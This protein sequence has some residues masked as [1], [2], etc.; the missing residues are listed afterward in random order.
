MAHP[1]IRQE[2]Y[3][4]DHHGIPTF[5]VLSALRGA[6][7]WKG[8]DARILTSVRR[9]RSLPSGS[10]YL[11]GTC[12]A[13]TAAGAAVSAALGLDIKDTRRDTALRAV[14]LCLDRLSKTGGVRCCKEAVYASI[15]SALEVLQTC[16]PGCSALSS[17][18]TLCTFHTVLP[19][20]KGPRCPYHPDH[21]S[22]RLA[23]PVIRTKPEPVIRARLLMD[24][25]MEPAPHFS[26]EEAVLRGVDEGSSPPTLRI[27][28][29]RSSVWIG[30]YQ[31]PEEDVN[32]PRARELGIPILRRHNPGGAVYQD[33]GTLCFSLT[34]P[35]SFIQSR[36]GLEA[37]E[38]LYNLLGDA[39][40][41]VLRRFGASAEVSPV[42]DV[43]VGSRKIYG[44]AQIELYSAF[45]H[46]GSF[47]LDCDLDR[48]AE[49]L[50]PSALKFTDRGFTNVRDRVIN[51]SEILGR[52]IPAEEFSEA[53]VSEISAAVGFA[54]EPGALT[55]REREMTEFLMEKKYGTREWTFRESSKAARILSGRA[56]KGVVI[57]VLGMSGNRISD[58]DIR[59]DFLAPNARALDSVRLSVVGHTLSEAAEIVR[60]F[61]LPGDIAETISRLFK[62]QG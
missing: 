34:F 35:K 28:R 31:S 2:A 46:S 58:L 30:L 42:N 45:S 53:L 25:E 57:L 15:E 3:G 18:R 62:E 61:R 23:S 37:P 9:A 38:G 49:L 50:A 48:M 41:R 54:F 24:G 5:A 27:R 29:S 32:L 60:S 14:A 55:D 40:V 11:S 13:C 43:K 19:D 52:S 26:I 8:S 10:C 22:D 1:A 39:A 12:G 44:S 59:G 33:P 51:L 36:W 20:C 7:L 6:G 16:I 56:R 47:L 21:A 4:P 17:G